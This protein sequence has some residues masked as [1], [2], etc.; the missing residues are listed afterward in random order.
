MTDTRCVCPVGSES[1]PA[2]L[3]KLVSLMMVIFFTMAASQDTPE[4]RGPE[5]I[6]LDKG[7][8]CLGWYDIHDSLERLRTKVLSIGLGNEGVLRI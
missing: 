2:L 5:H 4:G 7:F 6:D 3:S 8:L 1:L